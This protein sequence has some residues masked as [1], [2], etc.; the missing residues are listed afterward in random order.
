MLLYV[1]VNIL[2][3]H[4]EYNMSLH[5]MLLQKALTNVNT[6]L[7]FLLTRRDIRDKYKQPVVTQS[8]VISIAV[9]SP[10]HSI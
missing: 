8:E 3:E 1:V 5:I 10:V 9:I 2:S 4:E 7:Y 6:S